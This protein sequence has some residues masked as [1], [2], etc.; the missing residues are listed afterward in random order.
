MPSKELVL[1]MMMSC[2]DSGMINIKLVKKKGF[3]VRDFKVDRKAVEN[4]ID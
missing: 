2:I 3:T 4:D 1:K